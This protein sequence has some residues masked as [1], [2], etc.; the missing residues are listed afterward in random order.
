MRGRTNG[1]YQRDQQARS[2][3]RFAALVVAFVFLA[4][5]GA[6]ALVWLCVTVGALDTVNAIVQ[7]VRDSVFTYA[8]GLNWVI[9]T[10]YVPALVVSS[11]LIVMQL[12][13]RRQASISHR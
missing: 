7:S 6:L 5:G 8:L 10:M 1:L 2:G 13:R 12:L 4:I 9:V 3:R 11:I